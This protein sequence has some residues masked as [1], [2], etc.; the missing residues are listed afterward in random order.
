MYILLIGFFMLFLISTTTG[1]LMMFK[2][3]K[4]NKYNVVTGII[5]L[6]TGIFCLLASILFYL[7][8]I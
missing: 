4:R 6:G 1:L 5:A 3:R 7:V 8:V 2:L